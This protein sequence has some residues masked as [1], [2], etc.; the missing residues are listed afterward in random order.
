MERFVEEARELRETIEFEPK[1]SEDYVRNSDVVERM[2]ARFDQL[3]SELQ[4]IENVY[5]IM[6]EIPVPVSSDDRAS[7]KALKATMNSLGQK[8]QER[9]RAQRQVRA[10]EGI[11]NATYMR[12]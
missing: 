2:N 3:E 7:L 6:A 8:I 11:K 12:K 5:A 10:G 9:I 4:A 1:S